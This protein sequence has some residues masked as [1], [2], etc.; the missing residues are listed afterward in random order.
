MEKSKYLLARLFDRTTVQID[1]RIDVIP[2]LL[3]VTK[4]AVLNAVALVRKEVPGFDQCDE[5]LPRQI[6]ADFFLSGLGSTT[7]LHQRRTISVHVP[8]SDDGLVLQG[9]DLANQFAEQ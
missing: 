1:S 4:H 9:F 8:S 2:T 5:I 7:T 3:E 6:V